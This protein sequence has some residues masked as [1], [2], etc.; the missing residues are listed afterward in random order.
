MCLH[1]LVLPDACQVAPNHLSRDGSGSECFPGKP[2]PNH[3]P[4]LL[5]WLY[6]PFYEIGLSLAVTGTPTQIGL[7][8][9]DTGNSCGRG[10]QAAQ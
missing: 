9:G 6:T 8:K 3:Y 1:G 4:V 5:T 2:L 10:G 7:N